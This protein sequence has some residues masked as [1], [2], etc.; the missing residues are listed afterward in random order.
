MALWL[1]ALTALAEDVGS[2]PSTHMVPT[3]ACDPRS[4]ESDGLS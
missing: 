4:R 3:V 1:R 2:A